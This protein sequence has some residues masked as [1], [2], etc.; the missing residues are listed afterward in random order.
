MFIEQII[1]FE[2]KGPGTPDHTCTVTPKTDYVYRKTKISKA[3]LRV[4][5]ESHL[6][7][8]Q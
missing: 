1:Q 7:I 8:F 6:K 3:T 5:F 2:L 4:I